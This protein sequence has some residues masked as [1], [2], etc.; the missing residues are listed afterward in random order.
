M[1]S[2][3]PFVCSTPKDSSLFSEMNHYIYDLDSPYEYDNH[4]VPRVTSILSEMIHEE[5]LMN[6][7]NFVGRVKHM[8]H[9]TITQESAY[10]GTKVHDAI[11]K[12]TTECIL[13]DFSTEN[14]RF[15][16]RIENAFL[17]FV[18]WWKIISTHNI[19]ILMAEKSLVCEYYGGTLDMLLS[20]DGRIYLIDFKT[21]NHFSYKYHLQTAAY[22]RILYTKHNINIDGIIILKLSKDNVFFE[23]QVIDLTTYDGTIYI[24]QCDSFFLS[25]LY[26]YYNKNRVVSVFEKMY[27]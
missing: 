5:Y 17:S 24:D 11:N 3:K 10:I 15:K 7:A 8:N 23:E 18:E 4:K 14:V 2:I 25:L 22:R 20:V 9:S 19:E 13:P 27:K 26:A 12:Y 16:N 1:S 21:S 6:W